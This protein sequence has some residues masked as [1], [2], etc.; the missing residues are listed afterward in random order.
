MYVSQLHFES[1]GAEKHHFP[2]VFFIHIPCLVVTPHLGANP[3]TSYHIYTY[4]FR[5]HEIVLGTRGNTTN[6]S[7]PS[8]L[9]LRFLWKRT[10]NGSGG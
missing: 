4:R 2:S 3:F 6:F 5:R 1:Q 10:W 8:V 9:T 7:F